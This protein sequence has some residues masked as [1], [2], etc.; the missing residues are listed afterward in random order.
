MRPSLAAAPQMATF[1][2]LSWA[3]LNLSAILP[4]WLDFQGN[5]PNRV[6]TLI[7]A[8]LAKTLMYFIEQF[9]VTAP[10]SFS[11]CVKLFSK[12]RILMICCFARW[13]FGHTALEGSPFACRTDPRYVTRLTSVII[14]VAALEQP[15]VSP[16]QGRDNQRILDVA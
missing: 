1:H 13:A 5:M 12:G 2:W 8:F 3:K 10:G 6:H 9:S 11:H 15:R 16:Q 4:C 7:L 14:L